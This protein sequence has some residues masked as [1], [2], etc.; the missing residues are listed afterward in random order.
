MGNRVLDK[1]EKEQFEFHNSVRNMYLKRAEKHQ[2]RFIIIDATQSICDIQIELINHLDA[3]IEK[4][5]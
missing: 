2:D 4:H 5:K 1:F 3:I